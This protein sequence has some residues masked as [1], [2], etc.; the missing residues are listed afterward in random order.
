MMQPRVPRLRRALNVDLIQPKFYNNGGLQVTIPCKPPWKQCDCC[1]S[2][3]SH[4]CQTVA[5]EV[6]YIK[7]KY[8]CDSS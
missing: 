4:S 6:Q 8:A 7:L 1:S 3:T 5:L 2:S